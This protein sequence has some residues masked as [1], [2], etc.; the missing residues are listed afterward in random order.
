MTGYQKLKKE[1]K[2]LWSTLRGWLHVA[3]GHYYKND[4]P[5]FQEY[6]EKEI[7]WTQKLIKDET[8]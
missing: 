6:V 2:I 4:D 1:N 5:K 7:A 3:A 8:K